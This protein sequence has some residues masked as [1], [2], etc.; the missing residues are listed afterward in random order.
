MKEREFHLCREPWICVMQKDFHVKKVNLEE[1]LLQSEKYRGLAGETESQNIAIL[2]LLLA[3][4]HIVFCRQNEK[5]EQESIDSKKEA[6]RRWEAIWK[7]GTFPEQ[8]IKD[9]F[10]KWENRFWLFDS[11]YP[12]YQV[13][14][15]TGTN[16]PA[17]KM[18]GELVESNNKIQLFSMRSGRKKDELKFETNK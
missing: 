16:N 11:E 17:K 8:P 15:I 1:A 18:N 10:S 4:L 14:G 6:R 2:R 13:P 12:F 9:Y 7:M 5:G 3:V